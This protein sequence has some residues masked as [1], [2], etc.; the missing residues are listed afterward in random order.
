MSSH[1]EFKTGCPANLINGNDQ[2]EVKNSA[3]EI[4]YSQTLFNFVL[5]RVNTT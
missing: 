2:L 3:T 1:T 5:T 4:D